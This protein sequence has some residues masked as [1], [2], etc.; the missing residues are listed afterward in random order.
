MLKSSTLSGRGY[1]TY[2][3]TLLR[4]YWYMLFLVPTVVL[5]LFLSY[6]N[7]EIAGVL[8]N[9]SPPSAGEGIVY[10]ADLIELTATEVLWGS[11]FFFLVC[12][13]SIHVPATGLNKF[14]DA[15]RFTTSGISVVTV[16]LLFGVSVLA[17][18]LVT[19]E[20]FPNSSNEYAY[21]FQ[22]EMLGRGRLWERSHVLPD[23]FHFNNII[24]QDGIIVSKYPPG[25]PLVLSA[26]YGVGISPAFVNPVIGL[27]ALS[28]FYFFARRISNDRV[29]FWSLLAVAGTAYFVFQGAS[30]FSHMWSLL[31][32][33]LFVGSIYL[34]QQGSGVMFAVLAGFCLGLIAITRY[35]TAFLIFLPFL[36][37]LVGQRGRRSIY[38]LTLMAIGT[39]PCVACAL[40][41][42]YAITTDPFKPISL[43]GQ[44]P[45]FVKDHGFM[46]G[47]EHFTRW[48]VTFC[49][50]VSPALLILYAA[51]IWRKIR[52]A[53]QR[54]VN[55][56]DYILISLAL[57]Y[58]FYF[59]AGGDQYGPRFLFEGF[60]FMAL[61]VV[62]SALQRR[63]RWMYAFVFASVLFG[64]V[65]IPFISDREARIVDQHQDLFDLVRQYTVVDAVVLVS[66][67]T[68]PIRPMAPDDLTRNDPKFQNDVI[69]AL[70]LPGAEDQLMEFYSDRA[71]Y[72]YVRELDE[73]NGAL[74][75]ITNDE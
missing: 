31:L 69:Y 48:V 14:A 39:I 21:L 2:F 66:S 74:V 13:L 46:K 70:D 38:P 65:R 28:V 52:V 18:A 62:R 56:E 61:L 43:W 53:S 44:Y 12:A 67:G 8:M 9:L 19:L 75:R 23:F 5:F 59:Q 24:Q 72:R 17:T 50:W 42:N 68:S 25:W 20:Q 32:T 36:I 45:G 7:R 22:A 3:R 30:Y 6:F 34:Y 16:F 57:G 15:A 35:Y 55:P 29:A 33:L 4:S 37:C 73:P 71:F 27:L 11:F 1:N 41:Y 49:Y 10:Y 64:I 47:M 60:P 40:T 26:A 54:F 63:E 51:F 58:F